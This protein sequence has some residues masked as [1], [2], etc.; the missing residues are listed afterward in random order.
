MPKAWMAELMGALMWS[1]IGKNALESWATVVDC[2]DVPLTYLDNN[3]ALAQLT[4]GHKVRTHSNIVDS[5]IYAS[6]VLAN[7]RR[8]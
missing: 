4:K 1:V 6:K 3:Y 8:I 2:G 5:F 7:P